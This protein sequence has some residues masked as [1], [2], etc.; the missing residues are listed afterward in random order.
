MGSLCSS[1]DIFYF[2]EEKCCKQSDMAETDLYL[3]IF[4]E[5][6]PLPVCRAL[7]MTWHWKRVTPVWPLGASAWSSKC[8]WMESSASCV[9]WPRPLPAR[10]LSSLWHKLSVSL[11]VFGRTLGQNT[12]RSCCFFVDSTN[13]KGAVTHHPCDGTQSLQPRTSI[14]IR[15]S[16]FNLTVPVCILVPGQWLRIL[17]P[18]EQPGNWHFRRKSTMTYLLLIS[19]QV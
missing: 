12:L 15:N 7:N 11:V 18:E 8:G 4:A 16:D 19:W 14:Q 9:G 5:S 6:A 17:K 10:K 1:E 13:V 3:F 2:Y